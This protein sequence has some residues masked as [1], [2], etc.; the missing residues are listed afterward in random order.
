[1]TFPRSQVRT[2]RV[3]VWAQVAFSIHATV[4]YPICLRSKESDLLSTIKE[5]FLVREVMSPE[6]GLEGWMG[7]KKKKGIQGKAFQVK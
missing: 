4:M 5:G 2:C 3:S 1:M 7:F 6:F